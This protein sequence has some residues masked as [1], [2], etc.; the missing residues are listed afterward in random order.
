MKKEID[1]RIIFT[2]L[3]GTLLDNNSRLSIENEN[4]LNYLGKKGVIRVVATGRSLYSVKKVMT[5]DFPIDYLV[6]SSGAAIM[7]WKKQ[8]II[9]KESIPIE[10]Y[11]AVIELLKENQ[12]SFM[13][14]KEIPNNHAFYY[15]S[16][17]ELNPDF[18]K[19]LE[20]YK[21]HST[22]YQE[23]TIFDHEITQFVVIFKPDQEKL[24][25]DFR[26]QISSLKTIRTTSPL[27]FQSIWLEIF[28]KNVSKGHAAEWL[29]RK[30]IIL[31]QKTL[32]IGNDYND[33]DMLRW[34][35]KAFVVQNAPNELKKEFEVT[36]SNQENGFAKIIES[37]IS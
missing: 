28:P 19:R 31:P 35:R 34:T 8:N 11:R 4:A 33:L 15:W 23:E 5:Q 22:P 26:S 32:S 20:Y 30:C 25:H 36:L 27:D 16:N 10:E 9:Y 18:Q 17:S 12:L 21:S 6:F 13:I 7:N 14:H 29:C 37:Y 24:F 1:F 3:D 2:D